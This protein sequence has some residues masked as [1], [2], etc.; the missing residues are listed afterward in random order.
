MT[1]L[2]EAGNISDDRQPAA[3]DDEADEL[4]VLASLVDT[5][6]SLNSGGRQRVLNYLLARFGQG[7]PAAATDAATVR[8]AQI[9][10][11]RPHSDLS[12]GPLDIR[13]F[14]T[15]K[16]PANGQEMAAVVAYYLAYKAPEDQRRETISPADVDKYFK[17]AAF[18]LPT[19]TRTVLVSAKNSGYLEEAG[20]RGEYKL[21]PVGYN[22]I[23][24]H[25]PRTG[26]PA[27]TAPQTIRR[28]VRRTQ[29]KTSRAV[30]EESNGPS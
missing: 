12:T 13:S 25:L 19:R 5:L 15:I 1:S 30:S 26:Q 3:A 23:T 28:R 22:L 9:D 14:K 10:D 27:T 8:A 2:T 7:L 18:P 21:S 24:H 17:Q 4:A 6:G 20:N 16:L 29:G 11:A